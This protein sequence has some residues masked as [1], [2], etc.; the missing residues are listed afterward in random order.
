[1]NEQSGGSFVINKDGA[2]EC[3]EGPLFEKE[4]AEKKKAAA[5]KKVELKKKTDAAKEGSK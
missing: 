1:M 4:Q 3:K 5:K 2:K